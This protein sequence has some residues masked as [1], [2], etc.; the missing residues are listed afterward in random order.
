M[1]EGIE[2]VLHTR[3]ARKNALDAFA[4]AVEDGVVINGGAVT[5]E[6]EINIMVVDEGTNIVLDFLLIYSLCNY[7]KHTTLSFGND[8]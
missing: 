6:C 8:G 4:D 7:K 1:R 2:Q 3:A 5:V